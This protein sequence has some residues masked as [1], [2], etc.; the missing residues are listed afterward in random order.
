MLT[1]RNTSLA[2]IGAAAML[3]ACAGSPKMASNG[4]NYNAESADDSDA[5]SAGD[6]GGGD[7]RSPSPS[8][9]PR[10]AARQPSSA[11]SHRGGSTYQRR[12]IVRKKER[13][14]LGT[15]WG[16]TRYSRV[17]HR[18]FY[19]HTTY[20]FARVALYY[21]NAAG[22]RAHA[23][24]RGGA[25]PIPIR[26][27]SPHR[28]IN[29]SLVDQ[30]NRVLPGVRAGG[31][32][33]VVGQHGHRYTIRIQ[34][35][36]GGRYELVVSVD[37]LDVI[38]GRKA[39]LRKRGY[40]IEPYGTLNIDG[41]RRSQ[42]HVAAFRF[43]RVSNSYAARTSGARNVGVIGVAVFA[44]RG[45]QWTTDELRKRDTANPFPGDHAYARPPQ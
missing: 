29:I 7:Y 21:N 22:V 6:S 39:D 34:N 23:N 9:A 45:S 24:Y 17:E 14:G 18:T 44:E 2:L 19:R 13:P 43:G 1:T 31:K 8:S 26:V 30:Y 33:L 5:P 10:P 15:R 16:E 20:P 12:Q 25:R 37:G 40:I 32:T 3:A 28:G 36:T 35:T 42:T 41:F 27:Y 38:D 11:Y 4:G